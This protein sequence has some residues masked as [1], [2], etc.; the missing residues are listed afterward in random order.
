M[1]HPCATAKLHLYVDASNSRVGSA[2]HQVINDKKEPLGFYSKRMTE[3]QKKYSAYDREL[4]AIYQSIKHFRTQL[5]GR[6]FTVFTDHKPLISMFKKKYEQCTSRQ[7]RYIDYIGQFI[8]NVCHIPGKD[9]TIAD[10]LSRI[11]NSEIADI[12]SIE[13]RQLQIEQENDSEIK[14]L[15]AEN[16]T[17]SN[18]KSISIPGTEYVIYCDVNN[19]RMRSFI[20]LKLRKTYFNLIHNLNHPGIKASIRALNDRFK[21][22]N[23]KKECKIWTQSCIKCQKAKVAR[24][25]KRPITIFLTPD[26]RFSNIN[27]NLVGPLPTSRGFRYCLTCIDRYTHWPEIIPIEDITVNR[28]AKALVSGWVARF[29]TPRNITT[30]RGR[31]FESQLFNE[32]TQLLGIKHYRT[33]SYHP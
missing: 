10:L 17:N 15:I 27:I 31:Q 1:S 11:E 13:Y 6:E 29:G 12:D 33:T 8:T 3:T 32:L 9:N 2:L 26:E 16:K 7:L 20:P 5:E 25:N 22:P 19:N 28:V 23:I 18:L 24:H 14:T 21:W 4:L 30:D